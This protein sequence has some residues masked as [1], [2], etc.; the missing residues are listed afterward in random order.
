LTSQPLAE[1]ATVPLALNLVN[2][3]EARK[4]ITAAVQTTAPITH[5]YAVPPGTPKDHV[6]VFQ[7]S[8]MATMKDPEF[9][10]DAK[11]SSLEINPPAARTQERLS[12]ASSS[13]NQAWSQR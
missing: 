12:I 9:L 11:K 8:F 7:T 13:W 3:D 1:L 4:L 6:K 10:A 5:L 2:N